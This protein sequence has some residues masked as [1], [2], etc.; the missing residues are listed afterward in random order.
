MSEGAA[1]RSPG[2]AAIEAPMPVPARF[3]L[4][5]DLLVIGYGAAGAAAALEAA[6]R[7]L[8][9]LLVDRFSGGGASLLSGGIV[10]AGGGT[11]QQ[12]QAGRRDTP[13][14]MARYLARE[15]GDAVSA[16]TIRK[17]CDGSAAMLAWLE[18]RGVQFDAA[19]APHET[20]YP[21]RDHY[22]YFSGNEMVPAN[23][24]DIPPA[25]RGHRAK[26]A[27]LSGRAMMEALMARVTATR[28]ITIRTETAARR[29]IVDSMGGIV[30]AE[31]MALPP[32]SAAARRHRFLHRWARVI[33]LQV[34]GISD[35]LMRRMAAIEARH[36]APLRV[37]ARLGVVLAA[38]GFVKNRAMMERHAPEFLKGFP[39]GSSGCDGSGIRLGLSAGGRLEKANSVSAWRFI[40]PPHAFAKGIVVDPA[41]R[42]LTNEEQYGARLGDALMRR[43]GGRAFV[44]LDAALRAEAKAEIAGGSLWGFQSF[45]ARYILAMAKKADTIAALAAK[46]GMAPDVLMASVEANNAACH[47]APDPV[48]K[49]DEM[50]GAIAQGPFYALDISAGSSTFPL[51]VLTLG[52]LAVDEASGAVLNQ[53]GEAVPGLYAVGRTARGL[54]SNFYVSGLSLGDCI[55]SGR[56]TAIHL[57]SG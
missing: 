19:E 31:L 50:R 11:R 1:D 8:D 12:I 44:I 7:G 5:C 16:E 2:C 35:L 9:V 38:G 18:A 57:A 33:A 49:S 39:L 36:A 22:L 46:L 43:G 42:R 14:A 3:D 45:P 30:G 29:L 13:E 24:A 41:G 10:Y 6:E 54:P 17:Y 55:W 15:V 32:G 51:P 53:A 37:R 28:G 23:R 21:S 48:G 40:N 20:S 25:P 56:R 47:G 27:W 52:G 26:G 34:S 4:E